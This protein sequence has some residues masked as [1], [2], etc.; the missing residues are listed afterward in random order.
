MDLVTA[1]GSPFP[2]PRPAFVAS[3]RPCM[4]SMVY[5]LCISFFLSWL[6]SSLLFSLRFIFC[7]LDILSYTDIYYIMF[8]SLWGSRSHC[9]LFFLSRDIGYGAI[10]PRLRPARAPQ[11]RFPIRPPFRP[12]LLRPR[13]LP[14][15]VIYGRV[16]HAHLKFPRIAPRL[17]VV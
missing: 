5:G 15:T 11:N 16:W 8:R 14:G 17:G 13:R 6:F 2:F 12:V 7:I 1:Q 9:D 4:I 10:L 3:L